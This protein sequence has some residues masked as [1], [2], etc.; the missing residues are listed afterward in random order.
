[1][2]SHSSPVTRHSSLIFGLYHFANQG[3]CSWYE[4]AEEIIALARK[5]GE[6]VVTQRI[7]P[8]T[9]GEYPLPAKRPAYSVLSKE[10]YIQATGASVPDWRQSLGKY[11]LERG[12]Y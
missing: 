1:M 9:T 8:I 10:K 6:P 4:F 3:Q 2:T 11:F 12:K 7:V 5:H